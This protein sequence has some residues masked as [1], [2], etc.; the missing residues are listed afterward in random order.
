MSSLARRT[1]QNERREYANYLNSA[2]WKKRRIAYFEGV[3]RR[4]FEPGCQVCYGT[5]TGLGSLDLHHVS[6]EGVS[7]D[8][9][10]GFWVSKEPD[11]D[12][13]PLCR[14]CH[15]RLH[16]LLDDNRYDYWGWDRKRATVVLMSHMRKARTSRR[17]VTRKVKD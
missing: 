1:N 4:G 13:V 15:E 7:K 10:T 9:K 8:S 5:L 14:E 12:L 16:Q 11:G 2:A 3:R 17:N 6:Y